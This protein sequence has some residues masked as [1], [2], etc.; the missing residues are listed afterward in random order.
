M[1]VAPEVPCVA[2][3]LGLSR[4]VAARWERHPTLTPG[5]AASAEHGGAFYGPNQINLWNTA[6]RTPT[7]PAT[8][9][10]E[11]CARLYNETRRI[12]AEVGHPVPE[13]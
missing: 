10:P 2:G 11:D 3:R 12:L 9:N 1:R 13:A 4:C 5:P 7:N 6:E 8:K